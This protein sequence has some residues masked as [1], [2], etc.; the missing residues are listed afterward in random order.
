MIDDGLAVIAADGAKTADSEVL[1]G[2]VGG[3]SRKRVLVFQAAVEHGVWT[4]DE[5]VAV[6]GDDLPVGIGAERVRSACEPIRGMQGR[7]ERRIV[8]GGNDD[9]TFWRFRWS[10]QEGMVSADFRSGV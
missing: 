8:A 10:G 9:R 3:R 1:N 2:N 4:T 6:G 7:R 5:G